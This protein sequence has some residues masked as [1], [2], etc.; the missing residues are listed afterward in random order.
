M[1][2]KP[3]TISTPDDL[4]HYYWK[5]GDLI[6]F[7]K[8]HLLPTQGAKA[9]LT[10]RIRIYLSTGDRIS[11]Q[12]RKKQKMRD[13]STTLTKNTMVKNYNNDAET[14]KFFV[15]HL[16]KK[17][18]F[19][20]YLRQFTKAEKI[21]PN[22]TYGDLIDGWIAF[23]NTRKDLNATIAPQFEYNQFIRDFFAHEKGATLA[24]AISGWKAIINKKGPR[25]YKFFKDMEI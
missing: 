2:D 20:E 5:K 10:E 1:T 3:S 6:S 14:R 22:M 13:S 25:T 19:N 7:C 8:S 4:Q 12:T 18:K 21:Q 17:F 16:G 23:E 15:E 11:Y 9:D 24:K